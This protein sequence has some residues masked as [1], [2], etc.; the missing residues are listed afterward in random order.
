MKSRAEEAATK[1]W[2]YMTDDDCR[3]RPRPERAI[4]A[5]LVEFA[6]REIELHERMKKP[7]CAAPEPVVV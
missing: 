5:A 2:L 1:L 7:T 4:A 6:E 3:V